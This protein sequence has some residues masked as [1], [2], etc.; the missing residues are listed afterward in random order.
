MKIVNL[1]NRED[2][3][4]AVE[5]VR[6]EGKEAKV[7]MATCSY[8]CNSEPSDPKKLAFFRERP[9]RETDEYYCGCR[10]WD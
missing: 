3:R 1:T 9:E 2:C 4:Q 7:R 5:E 8:G 6:A 10:G